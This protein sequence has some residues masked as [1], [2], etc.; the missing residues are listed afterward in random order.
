MVWRW[1]LTVPTVTNSSVAIWLLD[2]PRATR[3][4]TSVSRTVSA[5]TGRSAP[6]REGTRAP[7]PSRPCIFATR[8]NDRSGGPGDLRVAGPRRELEGAE[9]RGLC[10]LGLAELDPRPC[11]GGPHGAAGRDTRPGGCPRDLRLAEPH[12]PGASA[13]AIAMAA[14]SA[15]ARSAAN[16]VAPGAQVGQGRLVG[17]GRAVDVTS[18]SQPPRQQDRGVATQR[19]LPCRREPGRQ[20]LA[21]QT[22]LRDRRGGISLQV[23]E[24]R[25]DEGQLC[26]DRRVGD[27]VAVVVDREGAL[28]VGQP[29]GHAFDLAREDEAPRVRGAELRVAAYGLARESVE[30]PAD[31]AELPGV[32]P[33]QRSFRHHGARP[34]EVVRPEG[35]GNRLV[36]VAACAKPGRRPAMEARGLAGAEDPQAGA[37][38]LREQRVVA[39]P[40]PLVVERDDQEVCALELLEPSLAVGTSGDGI[41]DRPAQAIE[42]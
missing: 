31:G 5:S 9:G 20:E 42:D 4:R 11:Q 12:R 22:R 3:R 13:R 27:R 7:A 40:L 29:L 41:A 39:V 18:G 15:I 36:V 6:D 35:V 8:A 14:R 21:R 32:E 24:A 34:F 38:D 30:P 10:E 26:P 17:V 2:R 19:G 25:A 1:D 33:A 16:T 37:K 28:G 23:R